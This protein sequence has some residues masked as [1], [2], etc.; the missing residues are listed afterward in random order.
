[1]TTIDQAGK[2]LAVLFTA[3]PTGVTETIERLY[4]DEIRRLGLDLRD[5]GEAVQRILHSRESRA[6]PPLAEI[7]KRCREATV[8]RLKARDDTLE[9]EASHERFH[10]D[11]QEYIR[12]QRQLGARGLWWCGE[13]GSFIDSICKH[14]WR[15]EA[16]P[17]LEQC[18]EWVD[19]CAAEGIE[20]IVRAAKAV[21]GFSRLGDVVDSGAAV[22]D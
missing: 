6:V 18:R 20:P 22:F 4:L 10:E 5:L 8:D 7:I 11:A 17:S 13:A 16:P 1:M 2:L 21:K 3:F 9:L 19:Y 14:D 12:L 15:D